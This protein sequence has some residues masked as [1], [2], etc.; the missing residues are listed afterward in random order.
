MFTGIVKMK[1]VVQEVKNNHDLLKLRID[2]KK[3]F[4]GVVVGSS[5]A[6][7]GVC[8]TVIKIMGTS[9]VFDVLKETTLKSTLHLLKKGDE[10]NV[11]TSLK[12]G[13]E[14]GGHFVYG[15]V[16]GVGKI[17]SMEKI[18]NKKNADILLT[19][20]PPS[21]LF[22]YLAPQGSITINGVSLTVSRLTK[23]NFSTSLIPFTLKETML[24]NLKKGEWV[25]LECDMM[26]KYLLSLKLKK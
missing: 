12:A 14:I 17:V 1:G 18:S 7:N 21:Q 19:V 11:E 8:L 4:K 13:D 9:Y 24:G 16:D 20:V 25:N 23:K 10:V 15:H 22:R 26:A 3:R 2:V 5:V 6:I